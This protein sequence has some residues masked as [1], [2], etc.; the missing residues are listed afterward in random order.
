M[1]TE[2][3]EI[4]LLLPLGFVLLTFTFSA[5]VS[6]HEPRRHARP[7]TMLYWLCKE[8]YWMILYLFIATFVSPIDQILRRGKGDIRVE[9]NGGPLIVILHGY[10]SVPTHWLFLQ[11]RL[12]ARG[13]KNVVRYSY[14]SLTGSIDGWSAELAKRL[15]PFHKQG[16]VLV[17]HSMGGVVAVWAAAKMPKGAVK[18]IITMGSPFEG[19][20]MADLALTLNARKLYPYTPVIETT[21]ELLETLDKDIEFTCLWSR[22]DELIVPAE[23]AAPERARKVEM[24]GLG[25]TGYHFEADISRFI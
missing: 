4:L 7:G 10:L 5:W 18:K 25:H 3:A 1:L 12:R 14:H 23:S 24:K 8:Y 6:R 22:F 11:R 13:F 17:G 20:L 15:E 21:K 19:T 9:E 16:I 2:A